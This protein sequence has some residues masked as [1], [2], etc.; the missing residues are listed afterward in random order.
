MASGAATPGMQ[1]G[2]DAGSQFVPERPR[3]HGDD[4]RYDFSRNRRGRGG[5][6][7]VVANGG[8]RPDANYCPKSRAA[9]QPHEYRD[10]EPKPTRFGVHRQE[11]DA[12]ATDAASVSVRHGDQK[13]GP[14]QFGSAQSPLL[15]YLSMLGAR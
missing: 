14:L 4:T 12:A 3:K 11:R 13:M 15:A 7:A 8:A 10:A 2:D 9:K 5:R 6:C 1:Q